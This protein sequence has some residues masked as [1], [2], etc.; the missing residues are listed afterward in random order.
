LRCTCAETLGILY[1]DAQ[2]GGDAPITAAVVR[3]RWDDPPAMKRDLVRVV[4]NMV[5]AHTANQDLVRNLEGIPLVLNCCQVDDH[6][7]CTMSHNT[8]TRTHATADG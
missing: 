5:H 7:P 8:H 1:Q 6:N 3:R 4:A 2:P